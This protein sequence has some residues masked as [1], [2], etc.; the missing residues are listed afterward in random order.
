MKYFKKSS[1]VPHPDG[2]L[3]EHVL[4][5]SI[6][7]ANKEVVDIVQSSE[8]STSCDQGKKTR[9]QYCKYSENSGWKMGFWDGSNK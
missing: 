2:P 4:S 9:G 1:L 3:S 5:S 7:A 6:A 8:T